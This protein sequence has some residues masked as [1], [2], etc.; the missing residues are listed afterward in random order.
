MQFY[1][2]QLK[3]KINSK[4]FM[5]GSISSIG[6][7]LIWWDQNQGTYSKSGLSSLGVPGV[8]WHT[9]ILADQLTLFQPGGT[10]Y[11]HLITTGT[12]GFSDLPTALMVS[13][14]YKNMNA[15]S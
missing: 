6:E 9:Q 13:L 7:F 3:E 2:Q 12:P 15:T 8:P 11:A 5:Y 1:F 4:I 10:N 14:V